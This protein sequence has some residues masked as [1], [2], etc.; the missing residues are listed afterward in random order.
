MRIFGARPGVTQTGV[1]AAVIADPPD[2]T[3]VPVFVQPCVQPAPGCWYVVILID[4][5]LRGKYLVGNIIRR[6]GS[7]ARID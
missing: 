6:L 3:K 2:E 7:S 1:G 5:I 4:E